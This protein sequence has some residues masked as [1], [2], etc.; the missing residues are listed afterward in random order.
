MVVESA[1]ELNRSEKNIHAYVTPGELQLQL[2]T[3][4]KPCAQAV[5]R[6]IRGEQVS[7]V[8]SKRVQK[9]REQLVAAVRAAVAPFVAHPGFSA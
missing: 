1:R 7:K 5:L 2:Q 8:T 9:L 4:G 3:L 6:T